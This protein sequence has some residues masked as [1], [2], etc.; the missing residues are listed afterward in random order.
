M[1]IISTILI[2]FVALEF[3]ILC[4]SKH[5]QQLQGKQGNI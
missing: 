4:I 1:N 5:S 2:I 3:S